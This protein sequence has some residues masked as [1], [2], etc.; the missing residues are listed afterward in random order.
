ML[1]IVDYFDLTEVDVPEGRAHEL[2]PPAR[3]R[4]V[5]GR[6]LDGRQ[7]RLALVDCLRKFLRVGVERTVPPAVECIVWA[8]PRPTLDVYRVQSIRLVVRVPTPLLVGFGVGDVRTGARHSSNVLYLTVTNLEA[9]W[10]NG[11]IDSHKRE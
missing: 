3:I 8:L 10:P 4:F 7:H 1:A 9:W 11:L 2:P 5:T 6:R